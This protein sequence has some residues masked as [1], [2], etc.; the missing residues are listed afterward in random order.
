MKRQKA[1]IFL[2]L[3]LPVTI[4]L[5]FINK[6][7]YPFHSN[8]SDLTISHYPNAIFIKQSLF[9]NAQ[10]PLWSNTIFS[11]Y[12]FAADPLSGLWYPP[13][14][15]VF[16]LPLPLGFN[17]LVLIHLLW[18]GMGMYSFLKSER[19]NT[20]AALCGA[21]MFE[22][23]PQLYAHYGAGHLT[24]VYAVCWTPW[25]FWAE[26]RRENLD[27]I[28]KSSVLPGAILGIMVLADIRWA[29]YAAMG[30]TLYSIYLRFIEQ[31]ESQAESSKVNKFGK[32]KEYFL[33]VIHWFP[34]FAVQ[35]LLGLLLAAPLLLPLA[36]FTRLSTRQAMTPVDILSFS[37]PPV[38]LLGILIPDMGANAETL[39]YC[40]A[41]A[42][43]LFLWILIDSKMRR[44]NI[45]WIGLILLAFIY[46]LG[47]ALPFSSLIVKLPGLSL[48]RVP[49]RMVFMAGFGLSVLVASGV[50]SLSG[51]NVEYPTRTR[52]ITNLVLTGLSFFVWLLAIGIWFI[53]KLFPLEF[54]WGTAAI[55]LFSLLVIMRLNGH[56]SVK[57]CS[58]ILLPLL[59]L[60]LI[61]V[62]FT[63]IEYHSAFQENSQDEE[64][65][66]A[67]GQPNNLF[68]VYSPSYSLPQD[69]A[70]N[71]KIELAD[72][73]DP[74][75]L[76]SYVNFMKQASGVPVGGYS[77]TLPPFATGD[78]LDDNKNYSP[79]A[80]ALGVLNVKFIVSNFDLHSNGLEEKGIFG[81]TRLYE[82]K[83]LLPRAWVQPDTSPIGQN[84]TPAQI[85]IYTPNQIQ[86]DAKGPG[87]LVLSE[88]NYPGWNVYI[89]GKKREIENAAGLLRSVKL[90]AGEHKL[91][92]TYTPSTVF[93]GLTL[94]GLLLALLA[95]RQIY[96]RI[97]ITK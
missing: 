11:G 82:N 55:T 90:D 23:L 70:A 85:L 96:S 57:Y 52:A 4:F 19:K 67:I 93:A 81:T 37:L 33:V 15:P 46:S 68:R 65:I 77:V 91:L 50:E 95:A 51:T 43:V 36:Q 2:I 94:C 71:H 84:I 48:L 44:K 47:S 73:I 42:V 7:P 49:A 62:D 74:L 20:L 45:F 34:K 53:N 60:D 26:K 87:L 83:L 28:K 40:G 39:T 79:D 3:L 97:S 18:G 66:S 9:D 54:V 8:Y 10:I 1:L 5:P 16:I 76:Q 24:M 78:P 30:W 92:F 22:S 88:I 6:Y 61:T 56:I 72:G 59:V 25:I 12:P 31:N 58:I 14:W 89:D 38:N 69:I 86:L 27:K 41:L 63:Q 13:G 64:L 29:A 17:L 21:V 80:I 35:L 75:Q 32:I